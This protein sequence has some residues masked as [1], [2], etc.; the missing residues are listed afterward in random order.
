LEE[1][2]EH[3]DAAPKARPK[4]PVKSAADQALEAHL[5]AT[6]PA[7]DALQAALKAS[8]ATHQKGKTVIHHFEM[9]GVVEFAAAHPPKLSDLE[10]WNNV[11]AALAED[12]LHDETPSASPEDVARIR[13]RIAQLIAS[14]RRS[15]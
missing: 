15:G 2:Q 9:P 8:E 6:K 10:Q 3:R 7:A 12:A 13:K 5:E 14:E 11:C 1:L 4:K